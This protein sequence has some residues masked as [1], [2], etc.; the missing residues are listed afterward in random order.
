MVIMSRCGAVAAHIGHGL[1]VGWEWGV[2]QT[3]Y[4]VTNRDLSLDERRRHMETAYRIDILARTGIILLLPLGLHMGHLYGFAPFLDDIG[5]AVM[6]ILS[7]SWLALCW[8]AFFKRE[9]D[10]GIALTKLDEKVR[11]VLIP[12]LFA[13]SILAFFGHGPLAMRRAL[14]GILPKCSPMP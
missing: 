3:S 5:L 13:V 9:T 14:T 1:L 6:W 7:L 12:A 11:F 10:V 2:F 4:H 8:A